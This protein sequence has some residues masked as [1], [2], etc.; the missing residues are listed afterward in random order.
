[1]RKRKNRI[2]NIYAYLLIKFLLA[3]FA[4]LVAQAVF[5]IVNKGMC[6]VEGSHDWWRLIWGNVVFGLATVS[7]VFL[8]YF[9]LLLLPWKLRWKRWYRVICEILYT[10]AMLLMI[11][12]AFC[13]SIY[14]Q[15]TLRLL[16]ADIFHY[17]T[18]GGQMG[19]LTWMFLA[20][21]WPVTVTGV[22]LL[23]LVFIIGVKM[24]W[25]ERDDWRNHTANDWTG[26]AVGMVLLCIMVRGGFGKHF[27]QLSDAAKYAEPKNTVLVS[28]SLYSVIRTFGVDELPP[29]CMYGSEAKTVFSTDF[30]STPIDSTMGF[31]GWRAGAGRSTEYVY[32]GDTVVGQREI[33]KNIVVLVLESFSQEY[34]GCYGAEKSYTP[35]LDSLA[36]VSYIYNGRSNGK[37]SIEAIPAIAGSIPTLTYT[38]YTLSPHYDSDMVALPAILR[39]HGYSTAF[40]HGTYNGVM[41]FDKYCQ[42]AGF[43]NYYGK[44]EYQ[45]QCGDSKADYDGAW[46]I[47][48]EPFM[49]YVNG[50]LVST[51]EPFFSMVFTV[52]S[53]H[54]FPIPEQYKEVF[55]RAKGESP[56]LKCISYT[57]YALRRFFEA[58]SRESWYNNTLF[59]I[60]GDHP[61]YVLS[62]PFSRLSGLYRIPMMIYDPTRNMAGRSR[63]IMQQLDVMPTLL[64]YLGFDDGCTC[65]GTS[66]FRQA[67][68]FQVAYGNGFYLMNCRDTATATICGAIEEGDEADLRFMKA[69]LQRYKDTFG[70]RQT[71]DK[72]R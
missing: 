47:Y 55:K 48:D 13:D 19:T 10:V 5:V 44:N 2:P 72:E 4:L 38:P 46:G 62:K 49:Q 40:Y 60:M 58:A 36:T 33:Y 42:D 1:M 11:V 18:V 30:R 35:F 25:P 27:I 45:G 69:Y 65:F 22:T 16:S 23:I 68:G 31:D 26:F 56:L 21:F 34:M 53:H 67:D 43:D 51:Q 6:Q 50:R 61:G 70:K 3:F 66:V 54:P 64:D 28:N 15:H 57:D 12:P 41:N 14:Y 29:D 37:K 39:R 52:T 7:S 63:R 59:V 9:V 20:D 17:L 71:G 32:D 8:P 24:K